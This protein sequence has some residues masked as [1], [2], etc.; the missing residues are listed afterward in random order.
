MSKDRKAGQLQDRKVSG[1]MIESIAAKLYHLDKRRN[2]TAVVAIA[3]SAMMVVVVFSTIMSITTLTRRNQQMTFGSQAEGVYMYC[4]NVY[5]SELLRNSGYF[6]EVTYAVYMGTYETDTAQETGNYILYTDETTAGWNFNEVTE[7]RWP[8]RDGEIVVDERFVENHGGDVHVGDV[9]P[10]KLI[11]AAQEV[12]QD[13]VVCGIC[14]AN[15]ALDEA[16]VYVSE[17]FFVR[18]Y[19]G[20]RLETYCRFEKGKYT[21]EDLESILNEVLSREYEARG[22]VY[23]KWEPLTAIN[24]AAGGGLSV[25]A[26]ALLGGMISLTMICAGLMVYT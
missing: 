22:L 15:D 10:I 6:D 21:D 13:A 26:M 7:G 14:T 20:F 12:E 4:P 25:G 24:P 19:S 8:Q 5:W 2:T 3:L 17:A 23:R 16:R 11:T 1:K 18:D 9:I